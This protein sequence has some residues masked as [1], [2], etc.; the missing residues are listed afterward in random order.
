VH[1]SS[2]YLPVA[3]KAELTGLAARSGRSEAELVRQAIERLLAGAGPQARAEDA[4]PPGYER[5]SLVGVGVGPGDPGLVTRRAHAVLRDADRV[6]VT[7]TDEHSV[8]RAEMVVRAVAPT[9]RIQRVPF[10]IT[11]DADARMHSL[12]DLSEV[13]VAATDAGELVA[14]AV[15]GDPSQRTVFPDLADEVR[16]QRSALPV[17]TEPGIAS[18]QA[19]AAGAGVRLG[20]PGRAL[21]VVDRAED[22]DRHLAGGDAVV[23]YKASTDA[24]TVQAIARDHGREDGVVAELAGLPGERIVAVA[25]AGDGPIAYLATVVFPS[26]GPSLVGGSP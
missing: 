22:L 8:G 24:A 10:T 6:I 3:L 26:P 1:K 19:A 2:I 17:V 13:V 5:P 15:L 4:R 9:T 21:V 11:G 16:R 14:V 25:D 18:Y 20:L 7:T 12:T 23:L